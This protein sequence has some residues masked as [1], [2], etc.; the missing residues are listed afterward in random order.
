MSSTPEITKLELEVAS[1]KVTIQMLHEILTD[2]IHAIHSRQ[3]EENG[4][5]YVVSG[6][7]GNLFLHRPAAEIRYEQR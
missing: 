7:A 1:L 3:L 5:P 2:K 4:R 6:R